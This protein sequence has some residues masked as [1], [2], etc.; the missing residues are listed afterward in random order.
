M[1]QVVNEVFDQVM[2]VDLIVICMG[3]D[4]VGGIGGQGEMD[5]WGGVF[6]VIK[7][8]YGKYGDCVIDVLLLES[9]YVGVVI[10]VVVCG[11]WFVV[12]FMFID[13]M[14]VCFD[15]IFN[16]VVK[17]CYMFGGNV[18]MLVVIWVMVGVGF[19]VVVQYSQMLILLF[20]YILGLKVVCL[21]NVYDIKGFLF[22]FICDNDF[23]IF[24]EYKN[25]YVYECEVLEGFYIIFFGEV[26]IFCDGKD[27]MIVIYGLMVY[28]L[29][30]VVSKFVKEGIEVE[31]VD[32]CMFLLLDMD[33][34]FDSVIK[35]G[36]LVCVD[37][38]SLCCNI[39]MDI[40]VQVVMYVFGVLKVQI[41][42]VVLLYVLVFFLLM[43]ED[44]YIFSVDQIV[45]VVCKMMKGVW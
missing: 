23:V 45:N 34:V 21:S 10:G 7:G 3:E 28:C 19:C 31:I 12:E 25:L 38:V 4:I 32:L 33:I 39:V 16:Q 11:M 29:F 5:V 44:F 18:E 20:M 35:I 26:S 1:K 36:C 24:C 15:Q 40:F 8:F 43:L 2:K 6:G 13:F 41:E 14:G 22:Q 42:M 27:C 37:E 9:V 17:F 30:E